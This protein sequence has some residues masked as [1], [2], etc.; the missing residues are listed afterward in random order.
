MGYMNVPMAFQEQMDRIFR[1]L[2][3]SG[4]VAVYIDDL[5]LVADSVEEFISR[6][7]QLLT[8]CR[9]H[10]LKLNAAKCIF[11][12]HELEIVG[13][14][15]SATGKKISNE[16][17]QAV[18]RLRD[19][20]PRNVHELRI[21]L[22]KLNY[23]HPFIPDYHRK[24][25]P[26]VRLTRKEVTFKWTAEQQSALE[27][28]LKCITSD[29]VLAYG[30]EPGEL[31]LKTD[32]SKLGIGGV[33]VVRQVGKNNQ[34]EDKPVCYISKTFTNAQAKWSTYQQELY[35]LVYAMAYPSIKSLLLSREFTAEIDHRNLMYI[36]V[37]SE[38]SPMIE[39]WK[40]IMLQYRFRIRHIP[41]EL[42]CSADA[43]SRLG[44]EN[45]EK[46]LATVSVS[47]ESANTGKIEGMIDREDL[48]KKIMESQEK[49][50]PR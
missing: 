50:W 15:V 33:L 1:E 35:A 14:T 11:G 47:V 25:M 44:H 30:D 4:A 36:S 2:E 7:R 26:L 5:Y 37:A 43:L 28:I 27:D 18:Q 17:V 45:S 3:D 16:R 8:I 31:V 46:E 49:V 34:I 20:P 40:L 38:K 10:N 6:M 39:R 19:H 21:L 42:N 22:G 9:R 48:M 12:A 13:N 24:V 23:Y 41:G 29:K 32:A